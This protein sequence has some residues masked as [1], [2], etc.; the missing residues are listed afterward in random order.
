MIEKKLKSIELRSLSPNF[1]ANPQS[2]P[3]SLAYTPL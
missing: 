1:L 3:I 2:I